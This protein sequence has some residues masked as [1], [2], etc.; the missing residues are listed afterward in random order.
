MKKKEQQIISEKP[1]PFYAFGSKEEVTE[2]EVKRRKIQMERAEKLGESFTK[3]T[4]EEWVN[5][6]KIQALALIAEDKPIPEELIKKIEEFEIQ[7][8]SHETR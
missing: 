1:K 6:Y 8:L 2:E 7:R 5:P 3:V 4:E